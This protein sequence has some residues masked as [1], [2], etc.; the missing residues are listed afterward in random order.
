MPKDL[1][2]FTV[3]EQ[4]AALLEDTPYASHLALEHEGMLLGSV[5]HD[6][7]FYAV[8]PG[9]KHLESLA[10]TL[11]GTKG[12]D[13]FDLVHIQAKH[14]LEAADPSLPIAIMVGIISHMFSD[15]T[16]HPMV[17]HFSGDYY[18]KDSE[19]RSLSRQRH[20]ALE[21]LMDMVACPEKVGN[22]DYAIRNLLKRSP[23]L[24]DRGLPLQ[25]L[26]FNARLP[27]NK[28]KQHTHAAWTLFALL[29]WA[30]PHKRLAQT[31][32]KY[33]PHIPQA[34]AEIASLFYA[35]QLLEQADQLRGD[36]EFK[37]PVSGVSK[38]ASL[39]YLIQTAAQ[40]AAEF[41][42]EIGPALFQGAKLEI[43]HGP[44]LET[45]AAGQPTTDMRY[46]ASTP[47][48]TLS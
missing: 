13:S 17:W 23:N 5:F 2:H 20:R 45:G 10:H 48:P 18:A 24:L 28:T 33:R 25:Q 6:A 35:P 31:L 38:S 40:K 12:E 34:A 15:V 4:T 7:L 22:P 46:F 37:H 27:V 29:Q 39:T 42:R 30:F 44:S 16:M 11:H 14:I 1:I 19:S 21:A 47:F 43:P 36:I 26:A 32:W 9:G 8:F 3:A 41:C